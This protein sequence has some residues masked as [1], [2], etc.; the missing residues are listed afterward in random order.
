MG[1]TTPLFTSLPDDL[2][3]MVLIAC[4][5]NFFMIMLNLKIAAPFRVKEL[6]W[7]VFYSSEIT[8]IISSYG[9]I[10]RTYQEVLQVKSP[11]S[12]DPDLG[13]D[14]SPTLF[15]LT[16]HSSIFHL[17][18]IDHYKRP[19]PVDKLHDGAGVSLVQKKKKIMSINHAVFIQPRYFLQI[20]LMFY[21]WK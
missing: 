20:F 2:K 14:W 9:N 7:V 18:Y 19:P 5:A 11:V 13:M 15:W 4:L 17:C 12:G 6:M 21:S 16:S 8:N 1:K 10:F 3:F